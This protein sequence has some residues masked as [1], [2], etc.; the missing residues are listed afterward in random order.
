MKDKTF[1]A[2]NQLWSGK[3]E[4]LFIKLNNQKSN[5]HLFQD[6]RQGS[7]VAP[8]FSQ[9]SG[10]EG[11]PSQPPAQAQQSARRRGAVSAEAISEED[12]SSYVKKV[13]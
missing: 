9:D 6:E 12:A 2:T 10:E 1:K 8:T 5:L 13:F 4:M 7:K 3:T 11:D